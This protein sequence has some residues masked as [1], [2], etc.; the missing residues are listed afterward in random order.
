MAGWTTFRARRG[1][2]GTL[3][4]VLALT[5]ALGLGLGQS[6]FARGGGHAGG[7]SAS[8][9]SH[10]GGAGHTG[11]TASSGKA[12]SSS[13]AAHSSGAK[14]GSHANHVGANKVGAPH[15]GGDKVSGGVKRNAQGKIARSSHA[16]SEFKKSHPCPSTGK[17]SGACPGYVID[18]RVAL[19]RG[20]ADRPE[21]MQWQ[22][23]AAAKAKDKTE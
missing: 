19:K 8:H 16:K 3:A 13:Q 14:S 21:N 17:S 15:Q 9:S 7:S 11:G 2:A 23:T 1:G 6:A 22:T 5:L 12:H 20:G 10:S 18:H 4:P